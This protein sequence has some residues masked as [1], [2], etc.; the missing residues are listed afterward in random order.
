[1]R[2][3]QP[4]LGQSLSAKLLVFTILFV[5][6]AEVLIYTPSIARFRR[7][8]LEQHIGEA[9]QHV[10]HVQRVAGIGAGHT[11][12]K[13]L[14]PTHPVLEGEEVRDVPDRR[15]TDR[16]A[17]GVGAPLLPDLS[18]R[19]A[20]VQPPGG[21]RAPKPEGDAVGGVLHH[22]AYDTHRRDPLRWPWRSGIGRTGCIDR[23]G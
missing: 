7:D 18:R 9:R 5:M 19:R 21:R 6:V 1:M 13:L 12:D 2:I 4:K 8:Y 10:V 16:F 20:E 17:S 14:V 3:N 22:S 11:A 15:C 23:C